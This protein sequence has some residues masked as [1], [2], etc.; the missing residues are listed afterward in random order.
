MS[1]L[2]SQNVTSHYLKKE[3]LQKLLERLFPDRKDFD[4]KVQMSEAPYARLRFA[5]RQ[6]ASRGSVVLQSSKESRR[7]EYLPKSP[8]R[9]K[10]L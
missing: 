3:N 2:V 7:R 9:V 4:I 6:P 5:N 10:C 1:E 8:E